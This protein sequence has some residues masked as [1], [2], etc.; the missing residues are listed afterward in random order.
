MKRKYIKPMM[1]EVD[2]CEVEMIATSCSID[3]EDNPAD[4]EE[5]VLV[6][7]R[8]MYGLWERT[9]WSLWD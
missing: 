4:E 3:I 9:S 2:V 1:E 7:E 6:K 5:E 8:D